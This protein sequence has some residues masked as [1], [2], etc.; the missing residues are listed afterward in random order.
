MDDELKQA[1][2]ILGV[3]PGASSIQVEAAARH[4][5]IAWHPDRHPPELQAEAARQLTLVLQA[6]DVLRGHLQSRQREAVI[7]HIVKPTCTAFPD[8]DW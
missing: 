5:I 2:Y 7:D 1:Q 4:G 6:R 8:M 3:Q